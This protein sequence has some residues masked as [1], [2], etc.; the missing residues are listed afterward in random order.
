MT[1]VAKDL[2]V[3]LRNDP[4]VG[5]MAI[6]AGHPFLH[7]EAVL[8]Y[9]GLVPVTLSETVLGLELYLPMRLVALEALEVGH[10]TLRGQLMTSEAS[11]LGHH[12]RAF[13]RKGVALQT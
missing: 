12:S 9:L 8:P 7:M 4:L 6:E 11:L 10:R 13:F 1:T 5:L 3:L 2:C